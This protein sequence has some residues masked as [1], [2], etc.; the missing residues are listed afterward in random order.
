MHPSGNDAFSLI[1]NV[2]LVV[3]SVVCQ[4]SE[5][6]NIGFDLWHLILVGFLTWIFPSKES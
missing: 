5:T 4:Y 2:S 1:I 3:V 6:I